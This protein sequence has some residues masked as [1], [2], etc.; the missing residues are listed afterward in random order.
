MDISKNYINYNYLGWVIA[1]KCLRILLID[2]FHLTT[3]GRKISPRIGA[4]DAN[5][6]D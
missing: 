2:D 4:R 3:L 5:T 6:V 1:Q